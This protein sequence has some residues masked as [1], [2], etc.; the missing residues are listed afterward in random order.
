MAQTTR[1]TISRGDIA[2]RGG[3]LVA[4][5]DAADWWDA[6]YAAL[7]AEDPTRASTHVQELSRSADY[8]RGTPGVTYGSNAQVRDNWLYVEWDG[9]CVVAVDKTGDV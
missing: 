3:V 5:V 1:Y 4:E 8:G 7:L 2:A 6:V 9:G